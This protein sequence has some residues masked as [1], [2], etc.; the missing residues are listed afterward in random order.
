MSD[1]V[2]QVMTDVTD[3]DQEDI[4]V[5]DIEYSDD[6][7]SD[8]DHNP[9]LESVVEPEPVVEPVVPEPVVEPVAPEPVEPVVESEPVTVQEI[10]HNVQNILSSD[11]FSS[12]SD[13]EEIMVM[14]LRITELEANLS[15]LNR[16]L[17]YVEECG[18]TRKFPSEYGRD[19]FMDS[20]S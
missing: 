6:Y 15:V 3:T 4:V 10:A 2:D 1:T 17:L 5:E 20:L 18:I 7:D 13:K 12:D 11:V 8:D 14:R 19:L 9:V 16:R